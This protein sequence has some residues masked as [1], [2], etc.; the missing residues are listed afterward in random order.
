MFVS[1]TDLVIDRIDL[2][3]GAMLLV[4]VVANCVCMLLCVFGVFV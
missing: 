1:R 4:E 2:P 3:V